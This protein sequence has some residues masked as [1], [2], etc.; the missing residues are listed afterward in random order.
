MIK[1]TSRGSFSNS[2]KYLDKLQSKD[3]LNIL[4]KYGELGIEAL[5]HATPK[6]TGKTSESWYY[7]IVEGTEQSK[8]VWYNSNVNEHVNI[9]LIL[10]YGHATRSGTYVEGIDYINP[11][12]KPT[13]DKL[14]VA[15]WSE[16]K[17]L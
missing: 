14:A 9:A 10:Q 4:D 5:R 3:Y 8:I 16:V 6:D 1:V 2:L 7:E 15:V 17:N 13:F 12:I 11:A